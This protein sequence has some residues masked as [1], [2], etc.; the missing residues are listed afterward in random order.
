ME[1]TSRYRL[2]EMEVT[3]T[4]NGVTTVTRQST[5][6]LC[7][8][9]QN[10]DPHDFCTNCDQNGHR[11]RMAVQASA[12]FS[13]LGFVFTIIA[14]FGLAPKRCCMYCARYRL[15]I[16]LGIANLIFALLVWTTAAG[17]VGGLVLCQ[18][19]LNAEIDAQAKSG[20][21]LPYFAYDLGVGSATAAF[22]L[23]IINFIMLFFQASVVG[24][25]LKVCC[26]CCF[27]GC[28]ADDA[29]GPQV[30]FSGVS[31]STPAADQA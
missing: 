23:G 4:I 9:R 3:T 15:P 11:M 1:K 6:E 27:P 26:S 16:V 21:Q 29:A 25:D 12:G 10:N 22:V 19:S 5:S 13:A 7:T 2:T 28:P 30:E 8:Q 17:A 20:P 24:R 18:N 14:F 31:T